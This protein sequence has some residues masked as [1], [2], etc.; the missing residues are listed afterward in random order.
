MDA[1]PFSG[2]HHSGNSV[3]GKHLLGKRILVTGGAGF[4]GSHLVD[5]LVE[6]GARV[7][8][9]DNF[10]TGLRAN[11][12][13]HPEVE[14][15]AADLVDPE[16]CRQACAGAE[17]V[18]HL[19]ARGSVPRS[20]ADPAGT[21]AV[22]VA[23]S[24][25]LFAAARDQGVG[26]VVYASSSSVYGDSSRLPRVEGA[27]GWPLSPYAQ[28]K[29]MLEH[30]ALGFW[31]WFGLA[32]L[33]L[34]FFNVFGPRQR[35]DGPYAAVIPRFMA[36][37]AGGQAP[38]IYG[39]GGQERDFTFVGDVVDAL[40]AAAVAPPAALGRCFNVGAGQPISVLALAAEISRLAGGGPEPRLLPARAGDVRS[41]YADISAA[42]ELPYSPRTTL[43]EGLELTWRSFLSSAA[44]AGEEPR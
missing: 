31:R 26:R 37:Y 22:N 17:W 32:A 1:A 23:G 25:A 9:L 12:A 41:S 34:R 29:Q 16:V 18:F 7:R 10:S 43:A 5:A 2:K 6:G 40:L 35:P 36:A 14:V 27:E 8:V 21:L 3:S 15:M 11:L 4:I 19:A 33:G 42:R 28:S 13:S 38:E 44:G 39:D 20:M 24:A 30:L